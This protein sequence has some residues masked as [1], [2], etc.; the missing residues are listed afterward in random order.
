M[1]VL[2]AHSR[3]KLIKLRKMRDIRDRMRSG[4]DYHIAIVTTAAMPWMT[5][6][7]VNPLLRAAY[8]AKAGKNVTLMMPW[9]HPV[10]Q[11]MIFPNSLCFQ[12]PLEQ[13]RYIRNWL[14]QHGVKADFKL[15]FYPSRYDDNRGSILPLGDATRYFDEEECDVCI[16]EEPEH[17]NWYH[18]GPNWRDRF[19]LVVG[20]VHTNYLF[21]ARTWAQGGLLHELS[22][23]HINNIMCKAYCDRVVKL[24]AI[25]QPLPRSLVCNVHGVRADFL[26]VGRRATWPFRRFNK[27]AYFLGKTLWAKGHGFLFDYLQRQRDLNIPLTHVDIYG[28]GEDLDEVKAVAA[29]RQLDVTFYGPTDH[30]GKKIRDYKL[31]VNPSESEVLSTTIAEALA[32]GKFVVI[33]RHPSNEFFMQFRNTLPYGTPDE[34]LQLLKFGLC[35]DPAP[36]SEDERRAI[37]WEGATDRLLDIVNGTTGKIVLPTFGDNFAYWVHQLISKGGFVGNNFRKLSGAG[38]ASRQGFLPKYRNAS[39]SDIVIRSVQLSPPAILSK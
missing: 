23:R 13:E 21:Y 31:F 16:L 4:K 14:K 35:H 2:A 24:S 29:S 20:V 7:A 6:T 39:V 27:G 5:G 12:S 22:L 33:K 8:L 19:K 11:R 25:I 15:A 38:V 18:H 28:K 17:L 30:A 1:G 3:S 37:S 9:L 36:L 32:M 10:E 26:E 34:F